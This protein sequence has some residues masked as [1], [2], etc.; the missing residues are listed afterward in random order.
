MDKEFYDKVSTVVP[1]AGVIDALMADL[2]NAVDDAKNQA[3]NGSQLGMATAVGRV[4]NI[5]D[6]LSSAWL[7]I[8]K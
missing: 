3:E 8:K 4:T 6:S 2:R 5:V 7:S 1:M